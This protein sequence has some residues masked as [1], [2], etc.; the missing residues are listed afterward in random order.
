[1]YKIRPVK[2]SDY[3]ALKKLSKAVGI[4]FTSMP[5]NTKLLKEKLERTEAS[6]KNLLPSQERFYW[7]ALELIETGQLIGLSGI[8]ASAGHTEPFF[9][10]KINIIVQNN[11]ALNKHFEH[12]ILELVNDY[13]HASELCSLFLLPAY[14]RGDLGRLMSR[15]R[16]AY[17]AQHLKQF[18]ELMIAEMRG[19]INEKGGS[20]FWDAL[21]RQFFNIDFDEADA[22]TA[23]PGKQYIMDLMPKFPI[24]VHLLPKEAQSVIGQVHQDTTGAVK[25]LKKENFVFNQY[26]DIFDGG[27]VLECRTKSIKTVENTKK[28]K[29]AGFFKENKNLDSKITEKIK[30][31]YILSWVHPEQGF[32]ALQAEVEFLN[33]DEINISEFAWQQLNLNA[34]SRVYVS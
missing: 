16:F 25:L 23:L 33:T 3:G 13:Q 1:M 34:G 32:Q 9:N 4:G 8:E 15:V 27:P 2:T 28:Y 21:G 20:P 7:F 12:Q 14:R 11:Y 18:S 6:F 5:R 10:Y 19:F 26:V 22:M 29:I 31:K 17:I 24:Y 30:N